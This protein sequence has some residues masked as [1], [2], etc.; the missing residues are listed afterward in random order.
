[1]IKTV[2]F[3]LKKILF[4]FSYVVILLYTFIFPTPISWV[5]FYF[6][7]FLLIFLWTT[8]LISWKDVQFELLTD[9]AHQPKNFLKLKT[10]FYLP[11]LM[12]NLKVSVGN[13]RQSFTTDIPCLFKYDLVVP[14]EEM[15]FIRGKYDT[16]LLRTS[17]KDYLGVFAHQ[18]KQMISVDFSVYPHHLS[19]DSLYPLLQQLNTRLDMTLLSG[20]H[21]AQ[22]RQLREHQAKDSLKDIDWKA[23]FK[24]QALMVKEYDKESDVAVT[25]IFLGYQ[26]QYFEALLSLA[27]SL[28]VEVSYSQAVT[29][30]LIGKFEETIS[31]KES[32]DSFLTIQP[33]LDSDEI[34]SIW[35]KEA[36]LPVKV[37]LISSKDHTPLVKE[38]HPTA[39]YS[40]TED[41]LNEFQIGGV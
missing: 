13:D 8:T 29:L 17:G 18:S 34:D 9:K 35:E 7:T 10:R 24:K 37:I 40:I 32:K 14:F 1:M 15:S 4:I 3:T 39:F 31:V 19:F 21:S 16:L 12:T 22:F 30:K 2:F 33:A 5:V 20:H 23:S 26:T 41:T 27:Y 25:I 36:V 11:I 6:F 28:Y 38:N